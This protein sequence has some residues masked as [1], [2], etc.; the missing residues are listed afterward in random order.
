ME[1]KFELAVPT[2]VNLTFLVL[3]LPF[4]L[5]ANEDVYPRPV[6]LLVVQGPRR[7][8]QG[9]LWHHLKASSLGSQQGVQSVPKHAQGGADNE[10][11][12]PCRADKAS[13]ISASPPN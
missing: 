6:K 3:F 4:R 11:D 8:F 9:A 12:E 10:I 1:L 2:T 13:R 5:V 7:L